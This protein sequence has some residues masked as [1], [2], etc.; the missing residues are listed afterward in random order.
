MNCH[1]SVEQTQWHQDG[2]DRAHC[3]VVLVVDDV[4]GSP[5]VKVRVLDVLM[6]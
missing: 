6:S 5:L 1:H 4:Q 3:L 2:R